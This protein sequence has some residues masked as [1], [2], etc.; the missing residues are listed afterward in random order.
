[1]DSQIGC[2]L[3]FASEDFSLKL[4]MHGKILERIRGLLALGASIFQ[5]DPSFLK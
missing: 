3:I 4:R 2:P 5:N 1:M